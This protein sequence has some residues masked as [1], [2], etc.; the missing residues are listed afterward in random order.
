MQRRT[1]TGAMW[2]LLVLVGGSH[3]SGSG[4]GEDLAPFLE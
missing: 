4:T 1:I 2:L 3:L